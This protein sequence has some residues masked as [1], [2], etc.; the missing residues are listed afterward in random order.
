M[1]KLSFI[2]REFTADDKSFVYSSFLQSYHQ[3]SFLKHVPNSLYFSEQGKVIDYLLATG[4]VLIACYPEEPDTIAG[5]VLYE[6]S[7]ETLILHWVYVKNLMRHKYV[8]TDIIESIA[9]NNKLIIATHITDDFAL[10]KHKIKNKSF[11]YDPYFI[12][13]K[14]L[15]NVK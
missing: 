6:Y 2:L 10:L 12:N 11:V 9:A 1:T 8:A 14:R 7:G 3:H 13:N 4:R 5:Y 15:L